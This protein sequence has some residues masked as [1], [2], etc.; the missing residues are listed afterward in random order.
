MGLRTRPPHRTWTDADPS[1]ETTT[2]TNQVPEA[3]NR[4]WPA[5]R[6]SAA[7]RRS[8]C[9]WCARRSTS[10]R[11]VLLDVA[12]DARDDRRAVGKRVV[13]HVGVRVRE[14]ELPG[15]AVAIEVALVDL[16]SKP[17]RGLP[18][19]VEPGDQTGL[20]VE[21]EVLDL[22]LRLAVERRELERPV[23]PVDV[24][25]PREVGVVRDRG[26]HSWPGVVKPYA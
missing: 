22:V 15:P 10:C 7:R 17:S 21:V 14:R 26:T 25:L 2:T 23:G 18:P 6:W 20:D 11:V 3:S 1:T 5:I 4:R 19:D 12:V 24:L 13:L 9:R 16:N 8:A